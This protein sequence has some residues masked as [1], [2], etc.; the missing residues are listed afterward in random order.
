MLIYA[1]TAWDHVGSTSG[2]GGVTAVN[3]TAPITKGGTAATP[4]IGVSD[5]TTAAKGVVQLA[6]ATAITAATAG[7][8]VDAAQL[9]A[10]KAVYASAG[11]TKTG[12][13]TNKSVTPAAG[14]ATYMP[15]DL[16]TLTVLP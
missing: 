5:A 10:V 13:I 11:E 8:V 1:G 6:D 9:D 14:K 2:T 15:L 3:V 4:L 16:T 7:R 12:T